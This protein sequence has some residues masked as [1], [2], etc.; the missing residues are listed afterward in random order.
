MSHVEG[1]FRSALNDPDLEIAVGEASVSP[2]VH[3]RRGFREVLG[4]KGP[5]WPGLSLDER[6]RLG[7]ASKDAEKVLSLPLDMAFDRRWIP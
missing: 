2:E 3:R 6:P 1:S 5:F 7:I 4:G